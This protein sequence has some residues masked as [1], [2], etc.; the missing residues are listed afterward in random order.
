MSYGAALLA[1][2]AV[3]LL[4]VVS[5]GPNFLIVTASSMRHGRARGIAAVLGI[6]SANLIWVVA[7]LLGLSVLFDLIP[8]LHGAAKVAG[9]AYLVYLA[10]QY[11]RA[12]VD[13]A[14]EHAP[15]AVR[16]SSAYLRGFLT[17]LTNPKSLVY[18]GSVFTLFVGPSSPVWVEMV[19][20]A[21]VL[22]NGALWY[23]AV[24]LFFGAARVQKAYAS[25]QR[26]LDR[27]A[28]TV[29]ALFG[30]RLLWERE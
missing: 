20:G 30:L 6:L 1:L 11:W 12:P 15:A 24:A 22:L 4:A 13:V 18:F 23:G 7:A 10:I 8:W 9:G 5:P 26:P 27:A 25:I 3:D 28:G 17:G 29:M 21:I 14:P 19:A 16:S 2:F